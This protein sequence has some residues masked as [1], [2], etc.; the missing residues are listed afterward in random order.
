MYKSL[1]SETRVWRSSQQ[2]TRNDEE[3]TISRICLSKLY[4]HHTGLLRGTKTLNGQSRD[5]NSK[6]KTLFQM[7]KVLYFFFLNVPHV[8][9][10]TFVRPIIKTHNILL[11]NICKVTIFKSSM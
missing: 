8:R 6:L 1:C 2:P 7:Q 9:F 3:V 4:M 10:T 11:C 5:Q